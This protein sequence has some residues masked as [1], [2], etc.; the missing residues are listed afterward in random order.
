MC[1][2]DFYGAYVDYNDVVVLNQKIFFSEYM[3]SMR[4]FYLDMSTL[5]PEKSERCIKIAKGIDDFLN[6]GNFM[7]SEIYNLR[8][9]Y[10]DNFEN[11]KHRNYEFFGDCEQYNE[12]LK[13]LEV[14]EQ[15][16]FKTDVLPKKGFFTD[17]TITLYQ[18]LSIYNEYAKRKSIDN[19]FNQ[20]I[21]KLNSDN[22]LYIQVQ[23]YKE[24]KSFSFSYLRDEFFN[25]DN[26]IME[27]IY[28]SLINDGDFLNWLFKVDIV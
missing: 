27:F 11:I 4:Q 12:V 16:F 5:V 23:L 14:L 6:L 13:T 18:L 19:I 8:R 17:N 28:L 20:S 25:E 15:L 9:D 26:E 21:T 1:K 7:Y 22:L 24:M 2:V 10:K 3:F